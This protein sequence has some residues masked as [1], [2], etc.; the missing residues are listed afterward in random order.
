MTLKWKRAQ[1]KE[2]E[3]WSYNQPRISGPRYMALKREYWKNI[4]KTTGISLSSLTRPGVSVLEAGCGPTGVFIL[5]SQKQKN[6][7]ILDP[8]LDEYESLYA[9]AFNAGT[10]FA[11]ALEELEAKKSYD[12][13]LV[14]NAIDHCQDITAFLA[15]LHQLLAPGGKVYIAVNTHKR[16]WT[17]ALW[18]LFQPLLE[19]HHPFHFTTAQFKTLFERLFRVVEV[20]DIEEDVLW[21]NRRAAREL[22]Q[23][24]TKRPWWK[25]A[26]KSL[27]PGRMFF[28]ILHRF[29][30]PDH[31]FEGGGDSLYR[32]KMFTLAHKQ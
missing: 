32:H 30:L 21:I 23:A 31:D 24:P 15:K 25:T 26:L 22:P 10:K 28:A 19:P 20:A 14:I 29:G 5:F 27:H 7:D 8:L 4:M 16:K 18:R 2:L 17:A 6:Y 1:K 3:C 9:H 11:C 13:I 12:I